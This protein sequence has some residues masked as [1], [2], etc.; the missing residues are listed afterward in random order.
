MKIIHHSKV[1]PLVN[2]VEEGDLVEAQSGERYIVKQTMCGDYWLKHVKS[3]QD[4]TRPVPGQ[5]AICYQ[6]ANELQNI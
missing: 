2:P 1:N 3:G 6:I 4:L 5:S